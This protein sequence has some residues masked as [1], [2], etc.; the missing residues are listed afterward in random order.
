MKDLSSSKILI[1]NTG[2]TIGMKLTANGYAPI[3]DYLLDEI[4]NIDDINRDTMPR[5]DFVELDTLLD[6]SDISCNEWNTIANTIYNHYDDY[7]GFVILHGT[8]T[9]SYTASALSFMLQGLAKPVVL[10]GS[11][12]PLAEIRSDG[13]DNLITSMIIAGEAI[14]KEVCLCFGTK[15]LRGNRSTKISADKLL[16]FDSPNYPHLAEIGI[17]IKYNMDYLMP[18]KPDKLTLQPFNQSPIGVLKIFPGIQFGLF[19]NIIIEKLSAVVIET[20]GT[21][22]IPRSGD[23][24]L[25]ILK[26]AFATNTIITV[27]SQCL[28]GT[29]S[30][31]V[32]QTSSSLKKAGAVSGK[33][34]TTEAAVTK[35]YYLF[36]KNL[37]ADT[38]KQLMEENLVGEL[39]Q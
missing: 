27:C 4:K 25:P 1:I 26:R 34:M 21:G 38:I 14:V 12:I 3:K 37:D 32:Y 35:L 16:A 5:W 31:G 24:L 19:E 7:T 33:D 29:V 28:A 17:D 15:L 6:S 18:S 39:T 22:N 30:L 11:Q 8:D 36:S 13:R 2:G 9:M 23:D 10:T 20:F